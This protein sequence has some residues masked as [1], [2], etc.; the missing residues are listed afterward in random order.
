MAARDVREI[1][2][3]ERRLRAE[4]FALIAGVDEAGRG[5]LAGPLVAAAAILPEHFR[6]EGLRDS[7]QLTALQ[8]DQWFDRIVTEAVAIAV[9]RAFPRRIDRRGLHVSNLKLLR[10]ALIRLPVQPDFVLTDGFHL[11]GMRWPNLS[12]KKGDMVCA[13]VAA[14]SVVAKVTRDRIMDRYHRRFPVYRFDQ[15]RGYGT[16]E[17]RSIIAALGPSPIHRL[18]FKG[19]KMYAEDREKYVGLY[20]RSPSEEVE[21]DGREE[22]A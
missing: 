17:H 20:G 16:A 4:G 14:A 10:Q 9:V 2:Q 6:V 5:A 19:L 7:K 15:N 8:R 18:S 3:Y 11:R 21:G 22:L 1:D 13:S 12:V